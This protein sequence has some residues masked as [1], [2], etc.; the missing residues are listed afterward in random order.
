MQR[1]R[2]ML[3]FLTGRNALISYELK[4]VCCKFE[5]TYARY[6]CACCKELRWKRRHHES[7]RLR[8]IC[9]SLSSAFQMLRLAWTLLLSP[10]LLYENVCLIHV[11]MHV[12]VYTFLTGTGQISH[13]YSHHATNISSKCLLQC[14]A[15]IT[16]KEATCAHLH[17]YIPLPLSPHYY[18]VPFMRTSR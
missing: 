7:I 18:L 5:C 1:C 16:I 3:H 12:S 10:V 8:D 15:T 4:P 17:M 9:S 14:E 13:V 6:D 11:C 2:T